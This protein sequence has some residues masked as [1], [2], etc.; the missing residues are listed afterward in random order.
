MS[1]VSVQEANKTSLSVAAVSLNTTPLDFAGNQKLIAEAFSHQAS[2]P[3][4]I[5]LFPELCIPSYACQDYFFYPEIEERSLQVLDQLRSLAPT[6]LA[7]V[8]L[9]L[10][11]DGKLYNCAAYLYGGDVVGIRAK[12]ML[13]NG[14]V[15]YEP[16]WF[17]PWPQESQTTLK[18]PWGTEVPF[19]DF[20]LDFAGWKVG[21]HIC[22]EGWSPVQ[23][24]LLKG[25]DLILNPSASHYTLKKLPRRQA[26]I[27]GNS[28]KYNCFYV[29]TNMSGLES[30]RILYDG[31]EIFAGP[32]GLIHS[33]ERM[34]FEPVQV[35]TIAL[36]KA[37][38]KK[39]AKPSEYSRECDVEDS[40]AHFEKAIAIGLGDYMRKT[41]CK[42]FVVSLSGGVDSFVT[43]YLV[44]AM[45]RLGEQELGLKEFWAH[46]GMPTIASEKT[47]KDRVAKILH[48][49][50]QATE[51][52][53]ER[54]Q[55]AAAAAAGAFGA[56]FDSVSVQSAWDGYREL[57]QSC[58]DRELSFANASDDLTL[59]NMQARVRSVLPWTVANAKNFLFLT[60]SNRSESAVGYCTM[61]GDTSGGVAPVA[62]VSKIF[63]QKFVAHIASC[64]D[65][66]EELQKACELTLADPPTAE[67][68]P[69]GSGQEDEKDLMPYDVL[70]RITEAFLKGRKWFDKHSEKEEHLAKYE[71]LFFRSQWKRDRIAPS[72]HTMDVSLDPK[73]YGRFPTIVRSSKPSK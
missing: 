71:S 8:G 23:S 28:K 47:A 54:T 1:V 13:A 32:E 41:G 18:L 22:E 19:G 15:Y 10:R 35:E 42:G 6:N 50:Y 21:T 16:R 29:Y 58:L 14:E 40:F 36:E 25:V 12:T 44:S 49:I 34:Q 26:M 66:P 5:L 64:K 70:E 31:G 65:T 27:L 63:L 38:S 72:F 51:N 48:C 24:P 39:A 62:G 57:A 68:R 46:I 11:V 4:D 2:G 56:T 30:G 53:G 20:L 52:S 61:D 9:A 67:L 37:E 69:Q 3:A 43:A 7:L 17:T 60:T 55:K 45:V 73:G 59:Q 33:G